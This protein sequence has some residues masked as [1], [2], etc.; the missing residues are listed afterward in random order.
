MAY[1]PR[2]GT[3][4]IFQNDR[5]EKDSHPDYRGDLCLEDGTVVKIAGWKKQTSGGKPFLSL[6]IDKPRDDFRGGGGGAEPR[7]ERQ[8]GVA[9]RGDHRPF[10]IEDEIPFASSNSLF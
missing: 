5:K 10:D 2:P 8:G 4:S 6:K 7:Q 1:E 3:G 9:G